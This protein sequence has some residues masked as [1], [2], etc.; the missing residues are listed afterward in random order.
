MRKWYT[1]EKL[2]KILKFYVLWL[3]Q[4]FIFFIMNFQK[5]RN[6]HNLSAKCFEQFFLPSCRN[7]A[8]DIPLESYWNFQMFSY[9]NVFQILHSFWTVLKILK[10]VLLKDDYGYFLKLK[11]MQMICRWKAIEIYHLF[12][13]LRFFKFYIIFEQFWKYQDSFKIDEK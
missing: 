5:N 3:F 11:I 6:Y 10:P 7:N 9:L 8:N 1:V 12:S 2:Q 4:I 13:V